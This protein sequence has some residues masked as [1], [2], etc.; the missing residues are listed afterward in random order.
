MSREWRAARESSS[1][2]SSPA[3]TWT[4]WA[5]ARRSFAAIQEK[6]PDA[7]LH[8]VRVFPRELKTSVR[9]L[10]AAVDWAAE[11]GIRLVNMSLGTLREEHRERLAAAVDR[12]GA[13]GGLVVAAA[14][15]RG[16][17]WWPGSL[18]AAVGVVVDA[19]LARECVEV[20]DAGQARALIAASPYP[21]PI[22]GVPAGEKPERDQLCRC[23][24][25]GHACAGAGRARGAAGRGGRGHELAGGGGAGGGGGQGVVGRAQ[26]VR[27]RRARL[28]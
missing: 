10:V 14:E 27:E 12:L 11:R 5:T 7:D 2:E 25:H 20:R 4:G 1:R 3:T 21:R 23:Q 22:P 24:R 19:S 6:A 17:K 26:G 15:A 9:A 13:A 28:G 18:P 16:R 8:A